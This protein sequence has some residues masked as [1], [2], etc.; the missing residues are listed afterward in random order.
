MAVINAR[1]GLAFPGL[2]V[3]SGPTVFA[4]MQRVLKPSGKLLLAELT[5]EGF[6]LVSRVQEAEGRVHPVGAS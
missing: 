1:F 4:E 3:D 5:A 2:R 6:A